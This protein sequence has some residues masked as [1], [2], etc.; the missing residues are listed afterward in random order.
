M[1]ERDKI[2]KHSTL[3][4]RR[5]IQK[6]IIDKFGP[7]IIENTRYRLCRVCGARPPCFLIPVT[8][9]GEDCP[10]HKPKEEGLA[11]AGTADSQP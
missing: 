7:E 1:K 11:D 2:I 8:I 3:T 10:Y 9:E 6:I 4:D 5:A